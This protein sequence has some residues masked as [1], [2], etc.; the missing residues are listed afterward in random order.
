MNLPANRTGELIAQ[1]RDKLRTVVLGTASA[2]GAPEASVASA[3]L[4]PGGTLVVYVSGLAAHTRNLRANG[5]VSVL[6]A[7]GEPAAAQPL[8][9]RRLT[10]A[11]TATAIARD[12]AEFLPLVAEF[13]TRFGP[14]I[15]LLASMPDFQLFRLVPQRGRL[16]VGFGQAYEIEP[17][18][19]AVK[20]R[21]TG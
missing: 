12:S 20:A 11:C 5:R 15:D 9:R 1:F 4:G 14:T 16:V 3:V 6:L 21:V 13:R 19:W 18:T 10:L 8:A 2:D 7:E 17:R